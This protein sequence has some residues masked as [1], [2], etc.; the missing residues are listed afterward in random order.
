MQ[1]TTPEQ[2]KMLLTRIGY[3]SI[4]VISWDLAQSDLN[5]K[6]NGLQWASERLRGKI[7]D[8]ALLEFTKGEIVR[9]PI[10]GEMLKYLEN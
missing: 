5:I 8:I 2:M 3:Q 7:S 10:I 9:N 1:Y 4:I 6:V